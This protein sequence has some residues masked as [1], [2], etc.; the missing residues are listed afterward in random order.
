MNGLTDVVLFILIDN[1]I[2]TILPTLQKCIF[3]P[4]NCIK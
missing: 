3:T 1:K 2:P 4:Y